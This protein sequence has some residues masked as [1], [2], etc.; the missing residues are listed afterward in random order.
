MLRTA[1]RLAAGSLCFLSFAAP[2]IAADP[3]GTVIATSGS[4]TASGRALAAGSAIYEDDRLVT[5][6]GNVQIMFVDRTKL[7]VGPGSTLVIERFL[8]R[9]GNSV[10]K[11]SIDALRGTFRFISGNS[12]KVAY[13]IRTANATIGIHGTAFDVSTG[14]G[15]LVAVYA[16][17]VGLCA[18]GECASVDQ[19]CG[20]ARASR[21]NVAELSGR[22]K[23]R[24]LRSLPYVSHQGRLAPRFR[25]DTSGC[26]AFLA[27]PGNEQ[28]RDN[29]FSGGGRGKRP[30]R[31]DPNPQ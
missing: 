31:P 23:A 28:L 19:Y 2:A 9:G 15:T 12:R 25:V 5:G 3:I 17:K 1:R 8:L 14:S 30:D 11:F 20:V 24:A 18:Y 29:D 16:G 10:R 27:G 26:Q 4:P 13:D 6:G 22:A 7:L 21:G